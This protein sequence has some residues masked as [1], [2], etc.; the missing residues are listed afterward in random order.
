MGEVDRAQVFELARDYQLELSED[1]ID[2]LVSISAEDIME[3]L[4]GVAKKVQLGVVGN[5]SK[6]ICAAVSRGYMKNEQF[7]AMKG[8]KGSMKGYD[9]G[10]GYDKGY[11]SKGYDSAKGYSKAGGKGPVGGGGYGKSD[12]GWKG[13]GGW[14]APNTDV[15]SALQQ[16]AAMG[17]QLNHD[18][19]AQLGQL[20]PEQ[21][22]E[23][24]EQVAR[25]AGE[26]RDPSN[27]VS[28]TIA[29][30]Y[31]PTSGKGGFNDWP[32]API[33]GSAKGGG[34]PKFQGDA[35]WNTPGKSGPVPRAAMLPPDITPLEQLVVDLNGESLWED[36]QFDINTLLMLRCLPE[37]DALDL[38]GTFGQ[39]ARAMKGKGKGISNIN[40]YIQTAIVKITRGE[41]AS[42]GYAGGD[43]SYFNGHDLNGG[44]SSAK[45]PRWA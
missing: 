5:P 17:I 33:I 35:P 3:C 24:L 34:L 21:A 14:E 15:H 10:K 43:H 2:S 31:Q 26:L 18:A 39:K 8:E 12:G 44:E 1:A 23:I 30:G 7:Y 28:A 38:I 37:S 27:Y 13:D 6:Y 20:Q 25:K 32:P 40:N 11:D 29:K 41:G 22:V 19:I 36:Q 4:Q 42:G 9:G 16:V 45:R